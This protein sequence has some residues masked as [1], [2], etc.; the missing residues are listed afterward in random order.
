M[1]YFGLRS[2]LGTPLSTSRGSTPTSH[3][4]VRHVVGDILTKNDKECNGREHG[5]IRNH[6][7]V[8]NNNNEFQLIDE[9]NMR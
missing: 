6:N 7:R 5:I 4:L 9:A 8:G 2:G 3:A 1:L